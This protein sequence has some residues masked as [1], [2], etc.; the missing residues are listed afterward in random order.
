[1]RSYFDWVSAH[2]IVVLAVAGVVAM[3]AAAYMPALTRETNP[4]AFIPSHHFALA[5]KNE[6]DKKFHLR[7]P[8]AIGV[9]LDRGEDVFNPDTLRLIKGLTDA[10]RQLPGVAKEDVISVATEFGV[11]FEDGEPGFSPLL[12]EIPN[13]PDALRRI[14]DNVLGYELYQGTLVAADASAASVLIRNADAER[15]DA[16]YRDL[17]L[18]LKDPTLQAQAKR[19]ERLVVA[20]EAA[21][22]A[23]MG[24]AVSDDALRM[25]FI[26]PV[27]MA[28]VIVLAYRTLR[29]TVLPLC[30]IGGAAAVALGSMSAAGVPIY[31]VT[32]GIFVIIMALGVA[33]SLH[34]M[35]QYYEE[36]QDLRHRDRR[37]VVVDAC[38]AIWFPL[39]VTTLTDVAG[40]LALYLAGAMP[41][42]RYFGLFTC[43]GVAAALFFSYTV[44][45]AGLALL[46]LRASYAF[47]SVRDAG[48]TSQTADRLGLALRRLGG[49]VYE[50]RRAVLCGGVVIISASVWG[51]TQ[52][53]VNDARI[54]AFKADHPIVV[55]TQA[56]NERFDGTSELNIVLRGSSDGAFLQ[57][58]NLRRIEALESFTESLDQVGG[59]HSLAGWV[60]RAHQKMHDDDPAF[61]AIPNDPTDTQF[62]LDVLSNARTS[63][64]AVHLREVV[65]ARYRT[66]NLIVR[67]PTSE[68]VHERDVVQR[69][70][71]Y[72][73]EQFGEGD[74]S[75]ALA[76][77]VF[78]D[79]HWLGM[80]RKTHF[81]SVGLSLGAVFLI[82]ALLFRSV[83]AGGLCALT[84]MTAVLINYALMGV[85]GI[86]LGVGTSMFA[87][88]AVGAGVNFP[89]HVL[90]RLRQ[91]FRDRRAQPRETYARVLQYTGRAL[92]FT[93][94][95]VAIG[96]LLLCVSEFR[97]LVRFGFLIAASILSSFLV[98]ITLLPALVSVLN[99]SFVRGAGRPG[100][101]PGSQAAASTAAT[102]ESRTRLEQPVGGLGAGLG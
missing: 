8:I 97:T 69:L 24:V 72:L 37:T 43:V 64:M 70:E 41:P 42:I 76:G 7:E 12:G 87:A 56:L 73:A 100:R 30:V 68:Y 89:I 14:R 75:A 47:L 85:L 2:P 22:R 66:A 65:D 80:I 79:Y 95:V 81:A 5:L 101:T 27:V 33:D 74:I 93:A 3:A 99:P 57:P 63:P 18:V 55:A 45:P 1:V 48:Q 51:A 58:D 20:G 98:S 13:D 86:Y 21:V 62:Y 94:L 36:H 53:V 71:A 84:V 26:C 59:T 49:Y 52:V 78:L 90:D 60:K 10:V 54:M 19:G 23:H 6:V 32:N 50:H 39:L 44:V 25:N 61:Y 77:R 16:L 96:F 31:I 15:A 17:V 38:S 4:D 91:E 11:F 46:P 92:F 29:G 88:I 102:P 28:L 9:L 82:T 34:L 40:F 35:G 67:M 83:I